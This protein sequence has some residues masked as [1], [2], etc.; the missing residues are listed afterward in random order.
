MFLDLLLQKMVNQE[1]VNMIINDVELNLKKK[2]GIST[3]RKDP[4][5]VR[6]E[7][8]N[9]PGTGAYYNVI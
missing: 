2:I 5:E 7:S 8:R 9:V 1:L 6:K 3:E 4:F